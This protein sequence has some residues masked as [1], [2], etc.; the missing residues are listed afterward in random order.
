M[1]VRH[2][3]HTFQ[4]AIRSAVI[5]H[6]AV[7][8]NSLSLTN[9]IL[10]HRNMLTKHRKIF[11][12]GSREEH[13]TQFRGNGDAH[14]DRD[15]Y[16]VDERRENVVCVT[17]ESEMSPSKRLKMSFTEL[18][19]AQSSKRNKEASELMNLS[20]AEIARLLSARAQLMEQ[21]ASSVGV[22]AYTNLLFCHIHTIHDHD[23]SPLQ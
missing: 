15:R 2:K 20:D 6:C 11:S 21:R 16:V 19:L 14:V 13:V 4:L 17:E 23:H 5:Q 18:S 1:L 7:S 22:A 12:S 8:S 9:C 3:F 10:Q